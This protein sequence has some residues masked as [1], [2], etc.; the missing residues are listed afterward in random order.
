MALAS[1]MLASDLGAADGA[2]ARACV[3]CCLLKPYDPALAERAVARLPTSV[4]NPAVQ[5]AIQEER[6]WDDLQD[7]FEKLVGEQQR[8]YRL[9]HEH[10]DQAGRVRQYSKA[11]TPRPVQYV[12]PAKVTEEVRYTLKAVD[13]SPAVCIPY[14]RCM[15]IGPPVDH[16]VYE[17]EDQ[18]E[19]V[20]IAYLRRLQSYALESARGPNHEAMLSSRASNEAEERAIRDRAAASA[21]GGRSARVHPPPTV[22]EQGEEEGPRAGGMDEAPRRATARSNTGVVETQVQRA[23]RIFRQLDVDGTGIVERDELYVHVT[24]SI[25]LSEAMAARVF[26]TIDTNANGLVEFSEWMRVYGGPEWQEFMDIDAEQRAAKAAELAA[27]GSS[28]ASLSEQQQQQQQLPHKAA[29]GRP[30]MVPPIAAGGSGAVRHL[31]EPTTG[32]EVE[33]LLTSAPGPEPSLLEQVYTHLHDPF[34]TLRAA[35]QP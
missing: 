6:A 11:T 5:A 30:L 16:T 1:G 33:S 25:G 31:M 28:S 19:S 24:S 10:D 20:D 8:Q 4:Y 15:G 2:F 9:A 23:A 29:P 27:S 35:L 3:H 7:E 13:C 34:G 32:N 17:E 18:G 22:I 12:K 14:L 26:A 21:R